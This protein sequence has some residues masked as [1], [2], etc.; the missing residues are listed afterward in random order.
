MESLW[1]SEQVNKE[2]AF[3]AGTSWILQSRKLR[4]LIWEQ[5]LIL[6]TNGINTGMREKKKKKSKCLKG[7]SAVASDSAGNAMKPERVEEAPSDGKWKPRAWEEPVTACWESGF[8]SLA[9]QWSSCVKPG[10][11]S[12]CAEGI[13]TV[14]CVLNSEILLQSLF[15]C[16]QVCVLRARSKKGFQSCR[17]KAQSV[18]LKFE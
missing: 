7:T 6:E 2:G 3:P 15:C 8:L 1:G 16:F 4:T 10:P 9:L 18:S 11:E 17:S 5:Q 13:V 12:G 14:F